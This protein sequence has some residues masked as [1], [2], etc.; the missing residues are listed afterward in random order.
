MKK[1]TYVAL[2]MGI[3][4]LGVYLSVY[5]VNVNLNWFAVVLVLFYFTCCFINIITLIDLHTYINILY[6]I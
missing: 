1:L 2:T 6:L 5:F 3:A 4:A